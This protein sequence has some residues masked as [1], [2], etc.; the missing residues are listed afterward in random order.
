MRE[1]RRYLESLN[2]SDTIVIIDSRTQSFSS[3]KLFTK[4]LNTRIIG[5]YYIN[6]VDNPELEYYSYHPDRNNPILSWNM[7]EYFLSAPTPS[8]LKVIKGEPVYAESDIVEQQRQKAFHDV[9]KGV[10]EFAEWAKKWHVS[11]DIPEKV[12]TDWVNNFLMHPCAEDKVAFKEVKFAND[13][14]SQNYVNLNPFFEKPKSIGE[15]KETL[16]RKLVL[17]PRVYGIARQIYRKLRR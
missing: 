8:I 13:A 9:E 16:L 10:L 7:M 17:H 15:Y 3:Q 14:L 5:L 4:F 12:I 1:Y 11:E 6:S 2:L